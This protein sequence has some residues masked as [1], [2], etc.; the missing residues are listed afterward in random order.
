MFWILIFT[1][2]KT[3]SFA[4][5]PYPFEEE[6]GQEEMLLDQQPTQI[7]GGMVNALNGAFYDQHEDL[8]VTAPEPIVIVRSYSSRQRGQGALKRS[9]H[10]NHQGWIDLK[11]GH[12]P[13]EGMMQREYGAKFRGPSGEELL[14][15][16]DHH[17]QS[18]RSILTLHK[19]WIRKCFCNTSGNEISG[20]TNLKNTR[21]I[22][23]PHHK[24]Y[25]IVTGS[26]AELIFHPVH[27]K[28]RELMVLK[29]HHLPN[30]NCFLYLYTPESYLARIISANAEGK[31]HAA[32]HVLYP[33]DFEKF[34]EMHLQGSD[35]RKVSYYFTHISPYGYFLKDVVFPDET[36]FSYGY[37]SKGFPLL[38]KKVWP[39]G[40]QLTIC[41][42]ENGKVHEILDQGVRLYTLTYEESHTTVT[43]AQGLI[44]KYHFDENR[45]LTLVEKYDQKNICFGRE[46]LFWHREGN[47]LSHSKETGEGIVYFAKTRAYDDRGNV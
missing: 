42:H 19:K 30:R 35:G 20:R 36:R 40:R 34:P 4:Q 13:A 25:K 3:L 24:N 17:K 46:R 2:A 44:T 31:M 18:A 22:Y 43:D 15:F 1:F 45:R 14:F 39:D 10:L 23:Q 5:D 9:W 29:E 6:K 7:V 33:K 12:K 27:G 11:I 16:G 37:T 47:L 26:G 28:N 32:V 8:V 41:Y 21:F 38:N